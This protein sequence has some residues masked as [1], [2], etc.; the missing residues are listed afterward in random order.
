MKRPANFLLLTIF[1]VHFAILVTYFIGNFDAIVH[2][3]YVFAAEKPIQVEHQPQIRTFNLEDE[4]QADMVPVLMYHRIIDENDLTTVHF[5]EQGELYGTIITLNQF[6][7][8]MKYLH[9]EEYTALTLHEFQ[10]FMKEDLEVPK[11]SVLITFDDGF[12]DNYVNAYP[13]LKEYGFHATLFMISGRIDRDPRD[14]D[15]LDAQFLSVAEIEAGADVF[16]YMSHTHMF[17]ERDENGEAYLVSKD[18]ES[19]LTDIET[20]LYILGDKTAFAYPFGEYDDD[21]L[22]VL[23]E[24]EIEMAF[25]IQDGMAKRG[26]SL[27]EIPRRGIYHATTLEIF[28]NLI[29]YE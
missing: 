5:D 15:P 29:T 7:E 25:T 20:S 28:K 24:L 26:D 12:K 22:D 6:E 2:A 27:F 16:Q 1:F 19:I 8:Q 17:H 21:T 18:K 9:D 14:Y 4:G 13:V 11:N 10:A 3:K 23:K